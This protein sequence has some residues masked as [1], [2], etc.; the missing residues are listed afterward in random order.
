MGRRA[1]L[2]QIDACF[3]SGSLEDDLGR[4]VAFR[5]ESNLE[6]CEAALQG[7]LA[8]EIT[9]LPVIHGVRLHDPSQS[10]A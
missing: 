9:P 2:D 6:G 8:D 5:I 4:R 1:A 10:A 3:L 7:Y